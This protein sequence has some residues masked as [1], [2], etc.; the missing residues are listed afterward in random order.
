MNIFL[1]LL[2]CHALGDYVFQTSVHIADKRQ[3]LLRSPAFWRHGLGH[4]FLTAG[5]LWGVGIPTVHAGLAGGWVALSHGCVDFA[6]LS[7]DRVLEGSLDRR[8][9]PHWKI[10]LYLGDQALHLS[11]L[12]LTAFLLSPAP[13]WDPWVTQ[14]A[15]WCALLLFATRGI[16]FGIDAYLARF[17][18][19]PWEEGLPGAGYHIGVL[20]RTLVV[21]FVALGVWEGVGFLL[22]AKS[23]FRFGDLQRS[24]SRQTT[25]YVLIGTFLSIGGALLLTLLFRS[26]TPLLEP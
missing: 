6:K 14:L 13:G 18:M 17:S 11:A 15:A 16:G 10:H 8:P 24:E 1:L 12:A 23:I 4:G 26:L 25:E 19:P 9:L 5:A 7:L 21:V 22:A 3:R 20:E 2:A